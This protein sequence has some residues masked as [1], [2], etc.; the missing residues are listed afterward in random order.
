[1]AAIVA[2]GVGDALGGRGGYLFLTIQSLTAFFAIYVIF[3]WSKCHANENDKVVSNGT[4]LLSAVFPMI[5]L[6]VYFIRYFGFKIGSVKSIQAF[7]FGIF[8]GMLY[9]AVYSLFS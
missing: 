8:A 7:L 1:M 6:P 5:G 9:I 3:L 2:S 4:H